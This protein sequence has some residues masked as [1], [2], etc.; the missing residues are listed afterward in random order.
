M[1]HSLVFS[2]SAADLAAMLRNQTWIEWPSGRSLEALAAGAE[3]LA[4]APGS[5][6][7]VAVMGDDES[8]S[9]RLFTGASRADVDL[10][11]QIVAAAMN[12][13]AEAGNEDEIDFDSVEELFDH[14]DEKFRKKYVQWGAEVLLKMA[15]EAED[16]DE[17]VRLSGPY[18]DMSI[19]IQQMRKF[20]RLLGGP[21][22]D[23][24]L[25]HLVAEQQRAKAGWSRLDRGESSWM[26]EVEEAVARG[27]LCSWLQLASPDV[28]WRL[29]Q[30][31]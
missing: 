7:G 12:Q 22:G 11:I 10:G 9:V 29:L 2:M 17:S 5:A 31:V 21:D 15:A 8:S 18:M 27:V 30:N 23:A 20:K 3:V 19:P 1:S 6:R 26:A 28:A 25:A 16:P 4:A 13:G 24:L 14:Y